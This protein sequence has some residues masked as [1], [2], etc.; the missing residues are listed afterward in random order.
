[1]NKA[2][3][4]AGFILLRTLSLEAVRYTY[5]ASKLTVI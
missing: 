3:V 2:S 4:F 5:T 1:M